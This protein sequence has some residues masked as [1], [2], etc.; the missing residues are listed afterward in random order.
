MLFTIIWPKLTTFYSKHLSL[1]T[2]IPGMF[3]FLSKAVV[4]LNK[5]YI[6]HITNIRFQSSSFN[7]NETSSPPILLGEMVAQCR[8][9]SKYKHTLNI[10]HLKL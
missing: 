3:I 7:F 2:V 6:T 10:V 8:N 9:G 1:F 5:V 4:N